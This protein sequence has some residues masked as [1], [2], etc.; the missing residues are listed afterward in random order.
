[1]QHRQPLPTHGFDGGTGG[2][3]GGFGLKV[4]EPAL[5]HE[6]CGVGLALA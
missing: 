4:R 2:G 3:S 6:R 1:L 5:A